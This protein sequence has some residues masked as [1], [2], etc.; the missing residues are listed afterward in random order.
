[1]PYEMR[2]MNG[3]LFVND[4]KENEDQPGYTG[5]CLIGGQLY[6]MS[7]WA[8]KS[9]SGKTYMSFA[10]KDANRATENQHVEDAPIDDSDSLPF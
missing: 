7:A 1:M 4:K 6:Y 5:K 9:K 10:F 3:S 8:K 2:D